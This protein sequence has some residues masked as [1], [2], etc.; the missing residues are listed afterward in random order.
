METNSKPEKH[1][2]FF[3][4][5]PD[6]KAINEILA[7][8]SAQEE[9]NARYLTIDKIHLTLLFLD[10]IDKETLDCVKTS[11][12]NISCPTFHTEFDKT[13]TFRKTQILWLGTK[14][15]N[16]NLESLHQTLFRA[17]IHCGIHIETRKFKPHITLARKYRSKHHNKPATNIQ[18]AVTHFYLMESIPVE[19]GVRYE[20]VETYPLTAL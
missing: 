4:L 9:T 14:E 17:L 20:I 7:L 12:A 1:R 11:A 10:S 15:Q 2:V 16:A 8:Q 3:A 19:G 5:I 6:A 18:M 13:G